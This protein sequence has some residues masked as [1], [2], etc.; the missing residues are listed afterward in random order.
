MTRLMPDM[1]TTPVLYTSLLQTSVCPSKDPCENIYV[2]L[3]CIGILLSTFFK[4][5]EDIEVPC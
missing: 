2:P 3:G 5:L 4:E 1:F